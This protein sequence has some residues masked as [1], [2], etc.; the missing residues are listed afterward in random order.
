MSTSR[1]NLGC[2]LGAVA[3]VIFAGTL[4]AARLAVPWSQR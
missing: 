3:V 4:P 2:A 1:E